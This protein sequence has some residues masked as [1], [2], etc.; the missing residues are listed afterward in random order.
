MI[1]KQQ[2]NYFGGI[3]FCNLPQKQAKFV[4]DARALLMDDI[5]P[6]LQLLQRRKGCNTR[7]ELLILQIDC[8]YSQTRTESTVD[9]TSSFFSLTQYSYLG[10]WEWHGPWWDWSVTNLTSLGCYLR[11]DM[12]DPN[13]SCTD[14]RQPFKHRPSKIFP[15]LVRWWVRHRIELHL[16][17]FIL[18]C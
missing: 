6:K 3:R 9:C 18:L 4:W 8:Q 7:K 10:E 13:W 11:P 16:N 14:L 5:L 2:E 12:R 15:L 1:D 17:S